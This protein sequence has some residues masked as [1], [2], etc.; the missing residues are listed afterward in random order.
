MSD[1]HIITSPADL[2]AY[3]R[4]GNAKFTIK[5]LK[6][7]TR[8]TYKVKAPSMR[9]DKGGYTKDYDSPMR[10]VSLLVGGNNETDYIY[11]ALHRTDAPSL[12]AGRKGN[13]SHPAYKALE[14]VLVQANLLEGTGKDMPEQLEFWHEGACGRCGRT[15]TDPTSIARG[16]GPECAN[17]V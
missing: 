6:T 12:Y 7:G 9:T 15:L 3:V 8:Y 5:S 14:W 4:S 13:P 1:P 2:R 11:L 17:K 10:F 16:I